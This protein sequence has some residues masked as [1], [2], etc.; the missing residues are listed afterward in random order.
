MSQELFGELYKLCEQADGDK[1]RLGYTQYYAKHFDSI[2]NDVNKFFEIGLANGASTRMWLDYFPNAD[3]YGLENQMGSGEEFEGT[4]SKFGEDVVAKMFEGD[5][6][7]RD[8]LSGFVTKFGNDFDI[9][10]D[11][12]GHC[13]NEQCISLGYLF[14]YVKSGGYYVV[15]DLHTSLHSF[16]NRWNW[17]LGTP[18]FSYKDHG[19][20]FPAGGTPTKTALEVLQ[21]WDSDGKIDSVYMLDSEMDYLNNHI[22]TVDI[23]Y[24]PGNDQRW[25]HHVVAFIKK[26]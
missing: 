21:G 12:G 10:I 7:E 19:E 8:D 24:I 26:K 18:R 25:T 13:M 6:S 11:D 9:I 2:R 16:P 23:Y 1:N 20:N 3:I 14:P 4:K 5:Q 22:D 17:G 15:E